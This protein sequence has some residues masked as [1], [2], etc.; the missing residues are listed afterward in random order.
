[1][2]EQTTDGVVALGLHLVAL[3]ATWLSDE[4]FGG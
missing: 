4:S 3:P 1:M 2:W